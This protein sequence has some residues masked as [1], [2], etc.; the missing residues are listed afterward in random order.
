LFPK[1]YRNDIQ[2]VNIVMS[3]DQEMMPS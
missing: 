3:A 1:Y 2:V